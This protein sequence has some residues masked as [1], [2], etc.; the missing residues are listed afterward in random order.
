MCDQ[1]PKP[2]LKGKILGCKFSDLPEVF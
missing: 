1:L 2:D